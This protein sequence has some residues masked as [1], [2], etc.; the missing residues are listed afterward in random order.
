MALVACATASP[1][2]PRSPKPDTKSACQQL[3]AELWHTR[4]DLTRSRAVA[5]ERSNMPAELA[6]LWEQRRILDRSAEQLSSLCDPK[7][8]SGVCAK[9]ESLQEAREKSDG[10]IAAIEPIMEENGRAV[11]AVAGHFRTLTAE[12]RGKKPP[13]S[14]KLVL[15]AI[16]NYVDVPTYREGATIIRA[17]DLTGT[18]Y[19]QSWAQL[20]TDVERVA[21]SEERWRKLAQEAVKQLEHVVTRLEKAEG[22]CGKLP[23]APPL[24][25]QAQTGWLA[26]RD[27]DPR[28]T[29]VLL[30][31]KQRGLMNLALHLAAASPTAADGG[32]GSGAVVVRMHKGKRRAYVVTNRHVVQNSSVADISLADGTSY[33][34]AEV[35]FRDQHDDIAVLEIAADQ[36]LE[37]PGGLAPS[38]KPPHDLDE[39]ISA[40]FPALGPSPSYQVVRGQVSNQ[41][42][43]LPLTRGGT[44]FVIQHTAPTDPG[45]SGGPVIDKD[46]RLMA[47]NMSQGVDRENVA[48]AVPASL[49]AEAV[50][51]AVRAQ[52]NASS[53]TWRAAS[54]RQACL[55]FVAE[56]ASTT[57]K[58]ETAES[59]F[60][61]ALLQRRG[62]ES[63]RILRSAYPD[64]L[65]PLLESD[66]FGAFQYAVLLRIR[67]ELAEGGTV[68]AGE[69]CSKTR[70][71][72][73]DDKDTLR[74]EI[75]L[76]SGEK[77]EL[78]LRFEHTRWY[79]ADLGFESIR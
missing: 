71:N 27:A 1:P 75:A 7:H 76:A 55:G 15:S 61:M 62:L 42:F 23:E 34:T 63:V 54:A 78:E 36:K 33:G 12:C 30:R 22:P 56:F 10:L 73:L 40:G 19:E 69:T 46:G 44:S 47:I 51:R 48:F 18:P 41:S 17:A 8:P 29:T 2:A 13:P 79:V 67:D 66:V 52:D 77:R 53:D 26:A 37:I 3:N 72:K 16:Q 4:Q 57:I 9:V 45:A 65:E 6:T 5:D 25:R 24:T 28:K 20:T 68:N 38:A 50:I 49:V 32:F 31:P 59:M 35:I 14:C 70:L 21:E 74:F 58:T 39:V 60:S 11:S 43:Q 64:D